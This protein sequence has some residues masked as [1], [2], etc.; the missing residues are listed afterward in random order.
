[1]LVFHYLDELLLLLLCDGYFFGINF[2]WG[3]KQICLLAPTHGQH[4]KKKKRIWSPYGTQQSLS[5]CVSAFPQMALEEDLFPIGHNQ[6]CLW[7]LSL[8]HT[9]TMGRRFD[10]FREFAV[11]K[12]SGLQQNLHCDAAQ[13]KF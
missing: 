10:P 12:F 13:L 11:L 8:S 1:L 4:G 6:I 5:V 2:S 9:H 3:H 7:A